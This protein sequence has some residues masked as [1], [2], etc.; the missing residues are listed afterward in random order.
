MLLRY[1]FFI[2]VELVPMGESNGLDEQQR[3][4]FKCLLLPSMDPGS[5]HY[6]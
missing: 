3:R 1:V 6:R 5:A 2:N 4:F